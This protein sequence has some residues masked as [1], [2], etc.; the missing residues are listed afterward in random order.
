MSQVVIFDRT[1]YLS[2]QVDID[3]PKNIAPTTAEQMLRIL[4]RIDFLLGQAGTRRSNLL[5]ATIWLVTMD[6]FQ[7]MNAVW[8]SWVPVGCAPAR[9]TVQ[10]TL[11]L[12]GLRVEVAVIA[13]IDNS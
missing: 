11:A 3:D 10:S 4:H 1:V 2:G 6:D 9:A 8:E 7:E 12:P 13:A 5:S